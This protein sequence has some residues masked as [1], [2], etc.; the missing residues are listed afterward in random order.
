MKFLYTFILLLCTLTTREAVGA[1]ESVP[2]ATESVMLANVNVDKQKAMGGRIQT[3]QIL[4]TAQ[5]L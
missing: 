1:A 2:A 5:A 4:E 3:N